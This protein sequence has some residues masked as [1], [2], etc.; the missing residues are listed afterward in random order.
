MDNF[1]VLL[2]E[3]PCLPFCAYCHQGICLNGKWI[4]LPKE[5][6]EALQADTT[7]NLS[8]G[9]CP[10]CYEK[11]VKPDLE[12]FKQLKNRQRPL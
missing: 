11:K 8:H 2:K 7:G 3:I 12:A 10:L 9:C 4:Y 5:D 1:I 6:G